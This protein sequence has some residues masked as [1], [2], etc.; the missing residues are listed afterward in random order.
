M[1]L[2]KWIALG[3]VVGAFS[4]VSLL[5][6]AEGEKRNVQQVPQKETYPGR[7]TGETPS[8]DPGGVRGT[9]PP[10]PGAG[11]RQDSVTV[12]PPAHRT[13]GASPGT[14]TAT[15]P[16]GAFGEADKNRSGFIEED[17]A[18]EV[19]GLDFMQAD[20]D[21]DGRLSLSEFEAATGKGAGAETAEKAGKESGSGAGAGSGSGSESS[22]SGSGTR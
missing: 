4:N 18:S 19:Q 14:V 11:E 13:P 12:T 15:E 22:G 10:K 9:A 17:E 5:H 20:A 21:R 1:Q 8:S 2:S 3:I 16:R 7:V 6:A